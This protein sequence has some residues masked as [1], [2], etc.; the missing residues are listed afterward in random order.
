MAE[1]A[2]SG[3]LTR[4][5]RIPAIER[6]TGRSWADWLHIFEAADASRIG[7]SEIARVARAAVPDDLQSPDWWAQG[8]AIAYEQHVGIRV[9][10]QSTSGT[11]RVSASR[12]L[13]MDRDE[14]IDAWVAAHGS[15]VEHLGHAASAPRPSRTDKRSFWRFNLEGA[16]KVEVSATPKGEDR[17]ILGVSQD[18]LADGDRIEEWRAHWKALLAAL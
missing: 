17:V 15:V 16:G 8:I 18:G 2:P 7:H 14:A 13:P 10:G 1:P 9:P 4:G 5:E 3:N 11:F 12:T 6:A